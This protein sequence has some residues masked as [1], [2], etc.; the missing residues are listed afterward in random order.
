MRIDVLGGTRFIGR[1]IVEDL[2]AAGHEVVVV[3]R[4]ESEPEGLPDVE[5]VHADRHEGLPTLSGEA[6][7]DTYALS[8]ADADAPLAASPA[9]A[10]LVVLSSQDVYAAY[11]ELHAGGHA[12][13]VPLDE[14]S[15]VRADRFP[16][17]GRY[18]G[19]DDYEKLDVEERYLAR[20]GTVLRLPMVY[21]EH[22]YERRE[23]LVLRRVR[24]GRPAMP[25]GAGTLRWTKAYVADAARAVRLAVEHEGADLAGEVLNVGERRTWSIRRWAEEILAAAGAPLDLVT[26]ADRELPDDLRITAAVGQHLL[27]DSSKA[28]ELLGWSETAPAEAV[29][30]SVAWHL[31]NP[32]DEPAGGDWAADDRALRSAGWTAASA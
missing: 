23:D 5:H 19:M 12:H 13:A 9:G 20:G 10:R 24:A 30:R 3:H 21:G 17:R 28:R 14:T 4:G 16:Y 18:E 31:A 25:F 11:G 6:L 26:V 2:V 1:A 32:P 22:D 29:A 15:P 8:A 27:V 7:V